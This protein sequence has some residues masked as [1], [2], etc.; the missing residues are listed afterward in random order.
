MKITD[1]NWTLVSY[2]PQTGRSVWHWFDGKRLHQR[3]DYP[4]DNI[5]KD[6]QA[7]KSDMSGK[8]WGEG[9]RVASIPLDI[10]YAQLNEAQVQGDRSYVKRWLN[11][12]DNAKWRTFEGKV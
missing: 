4:V 7:A 5:I 2:D 1:G 6:N 9:Q 12:S 10:F 8:R 3:T 11:D